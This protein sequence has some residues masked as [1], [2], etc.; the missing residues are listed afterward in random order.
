M[1]YR[2]R[3]RG[4][5]VIARVLYSSGPSRAAGLAGGIGRPAVSEDRDNAYYGARR[6]RQP[7]RDY[8]A[9]EAN[10]TNWRYTTGPLS[11]QRDDD[12]PIPPVGS[13]GP[14]PGIDTPLRGHDAVALFANVYRLGPRSEFS[15]CKILELCTW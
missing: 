6:L 11:G 10:P 4:V 12:D 9:E 15:W 8:R 1:L 3:G 7:L 13:D 2:S 14:R 5:Q